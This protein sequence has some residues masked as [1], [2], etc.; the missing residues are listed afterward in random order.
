MQNRMTS[1][2]KPA[3]ARSPAQRGA[4]VAAQGEKQA[5]VPR[6]PNERDESADSQAGGEPSGA[7]V[8]AQASQDVER[9]LVDTDKGPVMDAVYEKV[10]AGTPEP[11][12]KFSR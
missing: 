6:L 10:R 5:K 3:A 12:K 7:R 8:G 2:Q 4:T 9:G 1:R 11:L